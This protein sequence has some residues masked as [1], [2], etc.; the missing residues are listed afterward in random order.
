MFCLPLTS[1]CK[2]EIVSLMFFFFNLN[3]VQIKR[4]DFR[5]QIGRKIGAGI[6]A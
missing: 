1:I 2:I 3:Y 6:A 4:K 5:E